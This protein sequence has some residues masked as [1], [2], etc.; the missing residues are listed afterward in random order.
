[1]SDSEKPLLLLL[2]PS[3]CRNVKCVIVKFSKQQQQQHMKRRFLETEDSSS[4]WDN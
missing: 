1:M 3:V 2:L 4:W